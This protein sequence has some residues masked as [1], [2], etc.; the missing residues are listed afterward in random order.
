MK[1]PNRICWW[2]N[3]WFALI[4]LSKFSGRW[5]GGP[6]GGR[7]A[8]RGGRRAARRPV[9]VPPGPGRC[10][11]GRRARSGHG[12][13]GVRAAGPPVPEEALVIFQ[14]RVFAVQDHRGS[15]GAVAVLVYVR[16]ERRHARHT[17]VER[18]DWLAEPRVEGQQETAQAGVRVERDAA[19][20]GCG[21]WDRVW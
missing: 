12:K 21:D 2:F 16:R 10:G 19:P 17:E 6:P 20:G 1:K 7:A 11:G 3:T 13:R 9:E 8:R 5:V 18:R 15:L 14:A 4:L